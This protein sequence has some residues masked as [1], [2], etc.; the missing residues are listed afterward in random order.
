LR[1]WFAPRGY[2]I[3]EFNSVL[4]RPLEGC[5]LVPPADGITVERVTEDIPMWDR[6]IA[7]GFAQYGPLLE[8]HFAAFATLAG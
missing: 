1:D 5:V 4:I 8:N 6:V 2:R 3:T 7:R